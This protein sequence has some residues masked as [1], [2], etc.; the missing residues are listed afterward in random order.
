MNKSQLFVEYHRDNPE[1]Y[2]EFER[3]TLKAIAAGR[4]NYGANGI[5]ELIRWNTTVIARNDKFKINNNYAPHYA[6]M[7]EERNPQ[8]EGF[9]RK[10]GLRT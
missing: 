6:R 5:V 4:K 8:H 1:I 9:F 7:F 2:V 10:R 3:L